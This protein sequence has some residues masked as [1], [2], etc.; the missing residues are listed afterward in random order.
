MFSQIST[1]LG[2]PLVPF[3]EWVVKLEESAEGSNPE[4]NPALRLLDYYRMVVMI[5]NSTLEAAGMVR[6]ATEVSKKESS[7]LRDPNMRCVEAGEVQK[8]LEYWRLV[9]LLSF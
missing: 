4:D 1:V 2:V 8:W 5:E 7:I 6:F 9:G 3:S